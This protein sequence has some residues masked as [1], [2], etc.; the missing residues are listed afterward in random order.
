MPNSKPNFSMGPKSS[1]YYFAG[2]DH[3]LVR[4]GDD[5]EIAVLET[6][7]YGW[8]QFF[9]PC[10]LIPGI[11]VLVGVAICVITAKQMALW[12][13]PIIALAIAC[14]MFV[15]YRKEWVQLIALP[16]QILV[17]RSSDVVVIKGEAYPIESTSDLSFEYTFYPS[18][19]ARGLGAF[20][21]LDVVIND[22]Q[23]NCKIDLLSQ[24]SNWALKHA[25]KLHEL[26]GIQLIRNVVAKQQSVG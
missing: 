7:N 5:G 13:F 20:S 9:K 14:T 19:T 4:P 22:G 6:K 3:W 16:R 21:E 10:F 12:A 17:L 15:T 11:I 26:T 24:K 8:W 23:K 1:R 2:G 25:R 18:G